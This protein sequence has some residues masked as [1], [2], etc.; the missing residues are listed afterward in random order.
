MN[1][2]DEAGVGCFQLRQGER[3]GSSG[4]RAI[5]GHSKRD[6]MP[7][8]AM[9]ERFWAERL[10]LRWI[11]IGCSV[12]IDMSFRD[13]ISASFVPSLRSSHTFVVYKRNFS[14]L[15]FFSF[16]SSCFLLLPPL[17]LHLTNNIFYQKVIT[18]HQDGTAF[19]YNNKST[20]KRGVRRCS[21]GVEW[22]IAWMITYFKISN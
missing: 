8:R 17:F 4:P 1:F 12:C 9:S 18:T 16:F 14:M 11:M 2:W 15:F 13:V 10:S 22:K 5:R 6:M 20:Q 3:L 7:W 21:R 19:Y